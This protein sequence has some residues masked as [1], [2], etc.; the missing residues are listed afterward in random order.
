MRTPNPT[1][2]RYRAHINIAALGALALGL[3]TLMDPRY[4]VFGCVTLF[5]DLLAW[6][7]LM[8]RIRP[9]I[10]DYLE[11]LKLAAENDP[12][13]RRAEEWLAGVDADFKHIWGIE[14]LEALTHE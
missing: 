14:S 9:T 1:I 8:G 2:L 6:V 4:R 12:R 10:A 3:M 11:Y 5:I 13:A 7:Y